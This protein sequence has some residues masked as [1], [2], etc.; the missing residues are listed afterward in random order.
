MFKRMITSLVASVGLFT[1]NANPV[2]AERATSFRVSNTSYPSTCNIVFGDQRYSCTSTVVGAF[3]NASANIKLCSPSYCFLLI[4]NPTQLVNASSG[5]YFYVDQMSWQEGN[6][7]TRTWN[8]SL[9]CG[10]SS[11]IGCV[12][13]SE[14]GSAIAL[15]TE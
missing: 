11:G 14:D 12:G 2:L 8:V 4:L 1:L 15:Y 3:D 13:T 7:I 5:E 9:T 6:Y 10:L